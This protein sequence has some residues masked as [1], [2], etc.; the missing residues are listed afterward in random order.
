MPAASLSDWAC[1]ETA[2]GMG[3]F[4][5]HELLGGSSLHL[6]YALTSHPTQANIFWMGL[7]AVR[8]CPGAP[9]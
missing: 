4:A 2:L 3:S 6:P 1:Q 5:S 8:N 9:S 7:L